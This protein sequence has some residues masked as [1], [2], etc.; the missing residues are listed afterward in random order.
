MS[1]RRRRSNASHSS[2]ESP[3]P[4]PSEATIRW[5]HPFPATYNP[6][7]QDRRG[8]AP[9]YDPRQQNAQYM[10]NPPSYVYQHSESR[11]NPEVSPTS[12]PVPGYFDIDPY[13]PNDRLSSDEESV[14]LDADRRRRNLV[15]DTMQ[16]YGQEEAETPGWI[17][18]RTRGQQDLQPLPSP[19]SADRNYAT[20]VNRM[21]RAE[22]NFSVMSEEECIDPDDPR[23]TGQAP[24]K[25]DSRKE[26]GLDKAALSRM[27]YRQRK[28]E[29]Q[30]MKI[31]FN[32]S[33]VCFP[34]SLGPEIL[35][36]IQ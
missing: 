1:F 21:E 26:C 28:K 29:V 31:E 11:R 10:I 7:S 36:F 33:C 2:A 20:G 9:P 12:I 25:R 19:S 23:V 22:S 14:S 34:C 3:P 16:W 15:R 17:R 30:R 27:N 4:G 18:E 35:I 5:R 8:N 13:D 24:N 6:N 32:V